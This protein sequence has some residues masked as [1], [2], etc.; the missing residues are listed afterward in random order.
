MN[1]HHYIEK[2][3]FEMKYLNIKDILFRKREDQQ[4]INFTS[5]W[6]DLEQK[7]HKALDAFK[8][9]KKHFKRILSL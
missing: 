2:F 7:S 1:H 6:G 5:K 4:T 8:L 3:L 9:D